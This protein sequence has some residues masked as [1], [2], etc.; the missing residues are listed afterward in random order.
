[1]AVLDKLNED[2]N[3]KSSKEKQSLN[4]EKQRIERT[5]AHL[6]IDNEHLEKEE[7]ILNE[8]IDEKAKKFIDRKKELTDLQHGI[9]VGN[10]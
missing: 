7:K 10:M 9:K 4:L 8:V 2:N 5:R 1:M 3:T 6:L